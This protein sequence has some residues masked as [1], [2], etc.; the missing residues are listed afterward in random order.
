MHIKWKYQIALRL[1]NRQLNAGHLKISY[2]SQFN[3]LRFKCYRLSRELYA[4]YMADVENRIHQ[5][6]K[7]FWSFVNKA[8]KSTFLKPVT[9]IFQ[10]LPTRSITIVCW[11]GSET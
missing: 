5:H 7:S 4:K 8:K 9:S 2:K 11:G 10:K 3:G 1:Q 6:G